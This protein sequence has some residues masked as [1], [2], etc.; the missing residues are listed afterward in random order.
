MA[1]DVTSHW[2]ALV[3]DPGLE[4]GPWGV[5]LA[6]LYRGAACIAKLGI[7]CWK[8]PTRPRKER[9]SSALVGEDR[10]WRAWRRSWVRAL[11]V[12]VSE[13]PRNVTVL[14][15]IWALRGETRYPR[16]AKK[17]RIWI[18]SYLV[19]SKEVP[20]SRRSSMYCSRVQ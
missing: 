13:T 19:W 1:R 17:F 4:S 18:V 2:K 10:V 7:Q 11:V 6:A 12:G 9:I 20:H 3:T 16:L 8:K 5:S 15:Q 14:V